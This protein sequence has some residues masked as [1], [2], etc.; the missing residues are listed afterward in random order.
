MP[1][2]PGGMGMQGMMIPQGMQMMGMAGNPM[3]MMGAPNQSGT[4]QQPISIA[5]LPGGIPNGMAAGLQAGMQGMGGM[6]MSFMIPQNQAPNS[7][8]PKAAD[9]NNAQ[10]PQDPQKKN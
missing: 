4:S 5:Q 8:D 2:G 3:G 10:K 7:N 9:K 6:P 1:Q